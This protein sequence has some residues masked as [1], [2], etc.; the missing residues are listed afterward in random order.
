MTFLL[1]VMMIGKKAFNKRLSEKRAKAVADFLTNRGVKVNSAVGKG[2]DLV[3][4]RTAV[5]TMAQ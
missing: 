1:G 5:V 3:S 4:G 2:I